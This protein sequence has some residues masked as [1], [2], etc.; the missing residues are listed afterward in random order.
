MKLPPLLPYHLVDRRNSGSQTLRQPGCGTDR[1][2]GDACLE[3]EGRACPPDLPGSD[4]TSVFILGRENGPLVS[5]SETSQRDT[6]TKQTKI[7]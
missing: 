1:V 4:L 5:P 3:R 6:P 7:S 2:Y